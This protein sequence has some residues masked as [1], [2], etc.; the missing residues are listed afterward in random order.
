MLASNQKNM[1]KS[2]RVKIRANRMNGPLS[3]GPIT[4]EGKRRAADANLRHGMYARRDVLPGESHEGLDAVIK[5]YTDSVRPRTEAELAQVRKLALLRWRIRRIERIFKSIGAT[6]GPPHTLAIDPSPEELA[7]GIL[8]YHDIEMRSTFHRIL[9]QLDK[10]H[11]REDRRARR[12]NRI[13]R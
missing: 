7:L 8:N 1:S 3:R 11:E 6:P 4:E 5:Q 13:S 12:K 10:A 2:S 9:A